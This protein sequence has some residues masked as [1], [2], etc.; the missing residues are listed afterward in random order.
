MDL[1]KLSDEEL[2]GERSLA[3]MQELVAYANYLA[4]CERIAAIN[5]EINRRRERKEEES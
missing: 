1:S 4:L 5:A 3:Q 2:R